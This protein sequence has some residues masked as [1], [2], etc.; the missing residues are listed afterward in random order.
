MAPR[1]TDR[2]PHLGAKMRDFYEGKEFGGRCGYGKTPAILVVDLFRAETDKTGESP[3][4]SNLDEAV[5]NTNRILRVARRMKPKPPII[6]TTVCFNAAMTDVSPALV[7][8]T[9][10]LKMLVEGSKWVELDPRI[11]AERQP[12]EPLI[13]KKKNSC[14]WG[15][16]LTEILV[17]N[18]V[19][20]LIVTGCTI[21][22]CVRA[23]CIGSMDL[24]LNTIV[25][26]EA[27]GSRDFEAAGYGLF[28]IDLK[29]GDVVSTEEVIQYLEEL[30]R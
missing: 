17:G 19:D 22:T 18:G 28:D 3:I 23:T 6:F 4:G 14:F 25:P 27:V 13:V 15:T 7:R 16:P 11:D 1:W 9:P 30:P 29:Y 8:K 12:D 24:G 20:T 21:D 10:L 26:F 2:Y 5:E